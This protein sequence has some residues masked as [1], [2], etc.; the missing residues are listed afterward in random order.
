LAAQ[1]SRI[2]R[3]TVVCTSNTSRFSGRRRARKRQS[4]WLGGALDVECRRQE[5]DATHLDG[6]VHDRGAAHPDRRADRERERGQLER[7][8]RFA[9]HRT[10]DGHL[11]APRAILHDDEDHAL[12]HANGAD[13]AG[14]HHLRLCRAGERRD[15]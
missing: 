5:L 13:E 9:R 6:R 14:D 11:H 15:G 12:G 1:Y 3:S 7:V 2:A 8:R 4:I 10:L